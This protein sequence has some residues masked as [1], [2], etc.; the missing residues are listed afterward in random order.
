MAKKLLQ[1]PS[2][3]HYCHLCFTWVAGE[4]EWESHCAS[5]LS[6]L[7][8][9][10]CGTLSYGYTLV[11]PGYSPFRLGETKLFAAQRLQ[12]STRDFDLWKDVNEQ[13]E[14]RR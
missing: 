6:S 5:H 13:L 3:I 9:K 8:T 7:A 11:R 14:G 4:D 10:R 1:L 12:S 2:H